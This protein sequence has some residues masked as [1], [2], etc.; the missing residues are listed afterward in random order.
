MVSLRCCCFFLKANAL[1]TIFRILNYVQDG[2]WYH[3]CC[4]YILETSSHWVFLKPSLNYKVSPVGFMRRL[5]NWSL[6][7]FFFLSRDPRILSRMER[8]FTWTDGVYIW[9]FLLFRELWDSPWSQPCK[10]VPDKIHLPALT[11][12]SLFFFLRIQPPTHMA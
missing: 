3:L 7:S 6:S 12:L 2:V 5:P 4:N 10:F 1:K 9:L 11:L 8:D